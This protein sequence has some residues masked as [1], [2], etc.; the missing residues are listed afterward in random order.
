MTDNYSNLSVSFIGHRKINTTE[1]I[2]NKLYTTI[3]NLI[4]TEKVSNFL[5]GS[6]SQ[7][8]DVCLQ[9]VTELKKK[10]PAV[11]RIYVRA[12]FPE[13]NDD[14]KNY[15]LKSY[16]ETYFPEKILSSGKAIYVERNYEMIDNCKFCI[17]Y[18]DKKQAT[19]KK[20]G[21]KIAYDYAVKKNKVIFNIFDI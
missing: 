11:K 2:M 3:E 17:F 21:T 4:V 18:F 20:S 15:L 8:N 6:K 1:D 19:L 7:F 5:F 14:Y 12:E 9:A 10:Y 16:D 13:I